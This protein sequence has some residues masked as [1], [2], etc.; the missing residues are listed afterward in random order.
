MGV[1]KEKLVLTLVQKLCLTAYLIG[2]G[3]ACMTS[4]SENYVQD[5]TTSRKQEARDA[6]DYVVRCTSHVR[7]V[8]RMADNTSPISQ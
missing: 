7:V 2:T 8:P 3:V 6:T 5:K 1:T 4:T